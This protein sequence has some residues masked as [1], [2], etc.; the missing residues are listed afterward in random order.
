MDSL[1]RPDPR[2][3][4]GASSPETWEAWAL[5][6]L[7]SDSLAYKLDPPPLPDV[8]ASA[9]G[10]PRPDLRRGRPAQLTPTWHKYKAP[11][12]AHALN[13][14]RK[15]AQLL[16][17][18]FH[19]ELQAAE[20]MCWALLN[21]G[22][23]PDAFARGLLGVCTDEIRHMN[24]Y[25]AQIA[26]LGFEIGAFPVRD[27]FWERAPRA[28]SPAEF[29]ALMGLGF[30][31]GNLDHSERFEQLFRAAGDEGAAQL[32]HLVGEEEISHVAFA[33]HW[34]K[35]LSGPLDFDSWCRALPTPLSPMVMRGHPLARARRLRAGFSPS[36]L[37]QLSA[38]QPAS[39]GG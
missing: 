35:Q 13:D 4:A 18:F 15:R 36:F 10:A 33:A 21:F 26:A 32:L 27:W 8:R 14:A 12:S 29:L 37:E 20:L 34:F 5:S 23:T 6:Y 39:P 16:H 2:E 30:E 22:D 28:R 9:R 24:M 7:V 19:H 3:R 25:R 11:K 38:W 1:L 17:T 31:A